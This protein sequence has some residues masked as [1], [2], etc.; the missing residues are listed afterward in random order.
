MHGLPQQMVRS[1]ES[2][3]VGTVDV[4]PLGE[5]HDH[6]VDA[7]VLRLV[8]ALALTGEVVALPFV[9]VM[10]LRDGMITL[11]RDYWDLNTLMNNVPQWW[12]EHIMQFT[13]DD[14]NKG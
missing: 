10:E 3:V 8:V 2:G 13:T 12:I 14:F 4:D 1:D 7:R 6:A 9:S 5:V 11:W